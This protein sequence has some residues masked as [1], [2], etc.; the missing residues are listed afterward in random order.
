MAQKPF[1]WF[2]FTPVET[3]SIW[4]TGLFCWNLFHII[5]AF[6]FDQQYFSRNGKKGLPLRLITSVAYDTI[7]F[8]GVMVRS[9]FCYTYL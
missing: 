1:G 7:L 5:L 2:P 9:F 8:I 4:T 6:I 3:P